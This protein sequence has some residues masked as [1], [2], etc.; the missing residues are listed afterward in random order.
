MEDGLLSSW[1]FL[2]SS[3]DLPGALGSGMSRG[4]D[5]LR[6]PINMSFQDS[7]AGW[8]TKLTGHI[9][10]GQFGRY[11]VLGA[12]NT[13][14]GYGS[15]AFFTAVLN[16]KVPHSYILA[17]VISSLLNISVS[18]F[19]YKWFVFKTKGN[20]LRE[21]TRCVAVYSG[22]ILFGVFMLP[23]LVALIR[24]NTRYFAEAPY[25]AGALLTGFMVLYSFLGHKKFSFR[26]P[27]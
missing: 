1:D 24:R 9:P 4:E 26:T 10:P 23:I 20:Y 8:K 21:W 13:L 18:F 25:I 3:R 22:G 17:S 11:L 12:W 16:D 19:G 14:F 2:N 6:R 5:H 27:V 7:V 15:F